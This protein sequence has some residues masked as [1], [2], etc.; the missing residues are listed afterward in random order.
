MVDFVVDAAGTPESMRTSAILP[1]HGGRMFLFGMPDYDDQE[2]P[3]Y[4]AFRNETQIITCV[5]PQCAA[6][7]QTAADMVVDGRA[8]VLGEMVTPRMPWEKAA[9]AFEMYARCD[10]GSLKLTLEL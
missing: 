3:W 10:A 2:F 1:R 6:F 5:G 8:S 9:E 7:F 4:T